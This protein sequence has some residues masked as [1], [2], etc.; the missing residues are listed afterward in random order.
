[1]MEQ[2]LLL[3]DEHLALVNDVESFIANDYPKAIADKVKKRQPLSRED[4]CTWQQSLYKKGWGAP[5]WPKKFGGTGWNELEKY[6]FYS[7]LYRHDLIIQLPFGP[8]MLAPVVMAFGSK[9]QQQT[10]LPRILKGDDIW[11]QGYSEPNSGS[12]LASLKMKAEK[13]TDHYLLNGTK[14]WTTAAQFANMIF[15]LVRTKSKGKPQ[16]GISFVLVD[17]SLPGVTVEPIITADREHEVNQ[18]TFENV[19]IPLENLVGEENKGWQYAKYLLTFERSSF[20]ARLARVEYEVSTLIKNI[21]N[22][23]RHSP[24]NAALTARLHS[25][26]QLEA[27]CVAARLTLYRAVTSSNPGYALKVSS[28]IKVLS[29]R[30]IQALSDL[31]LKTL[32][33]HTLVNGRSLAFDYFDSSERNHANLLANQ[34][35]NQRKESIYAGSN[36]IQFNVIAKLILGL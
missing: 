26:Y 30:L 29:T 28:I 5:L 3:S 34:Y 33:Q 14:I 23:I 19:K 31:N 7:T 11:C 27:D 24:S 15:C 6:L 1:M 20:G 36:E 9:A 18:I 8:S 22:Q 25:L 17:M 35:L 13:R 32:G 4:F 21:N 2:K 10:Y 16:E 12:D